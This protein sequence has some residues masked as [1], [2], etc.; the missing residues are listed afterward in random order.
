MNSQGSEFNSQKEPECFFITNVPATAAHEEQQ[1][2]EEEYK[3]SEVQGKG[4]YFTKQYHDGLRSRVN[5]RRND[6]V[7]KRIELQ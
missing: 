5:Q 3:W 7:K 4:T 2:S 6:A 1:T